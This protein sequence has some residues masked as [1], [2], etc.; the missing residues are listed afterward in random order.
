MDK[1]SGAT[2][3]DMQSSDWDA[4]KVLARTGTFSLS[5]YP[6]ILSLVLD[7]QRLDVVGEILTHVVDLSERQAVDLLLACMFAHDSTLDRVSVSHGRVNWSGVTSGERETSSSTKK[8][9]KGSKS[10]VKEESKGLKH[11]RVNVMCAIVGSLL[12]RTA[13]FSAV[14]LADSLRNRCDVASACLLMRF[15]VWAL[16]GVCVSASSY[17]DG[18]INHMPILSHVDV[19]TKAGV[20]VGDIEAQRAVSWIEAIIDGHFSAISFHAMGHRPTRALLKVAITAI[21]DARSNAESTAQ[22]M[23]VWSHLCRVV[24]NGGEQVRPATGIYQVEEL[25]L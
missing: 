5:Q 2:A 12:C 11:K 6:A 1:L 15:F 19:F 23:G 17:S 4:V 20:V 22:L 21:N 14:M 24:Y 3:S 10:S 13:A 7:A 8:A 9:K 18:A 25:S 16:R